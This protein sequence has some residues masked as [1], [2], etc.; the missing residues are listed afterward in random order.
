MGQNHSTKINA[1]FQALDV[2]G[3]GT[4]EKWELLRWL[5]FEPY[6]Q[7]SEESAWNSANKVML[8]MDKDG[9]T[10]ISKEEL[11]KYF[12]GWSI[13]EI[14]RATEVLL[15]RQNEEMEERE[16]DEL[17]RLA[18]LTISPSSNKKE[19]LIKLYRHFD[20]AMSGNV[21][22][23][24]LRKWYKEEP[25]FQ[26]DE[27]KDKGAQ[28]KAELDKLG[29]E[30]GYT[31]TEFTQLFE[32]WSDGEIRA[33]AKRLLSNPRRV[34][35]YRKVKVGSKLDRAE[36]KVKIKGQGG[37][38]EEIVRVVLPEAGGGFLT[39][40][41]MATTTAKT[42]K[43]LVSAKIENRRVRKGDVEAY[44]KSFNEDRF[45]ISLFPKDTEQASNLQNTDLVLQ[46]LDAS[47]M[48]RPY[49]IYLVA[50]D[51]LAEKYIMGIGRTRLDRWVTKP[52]EDI[53]SVYKLGRSLGTPGQFGYALLATHKQSGD[54]RAVKVITKTNFAR[55][56]ERKFHFQQ[57]RKEIEVMQ[58]LHHP[59]IVKMHE[60]FESP[61]D[62]FIVME[63]CLGGELFD[64]IRAKGTYTEQDASK[65]LRQMFEAVAYMHGKNIA[66]C[67]LKPDNFLFVTT[68]EDSK[69][70]VI[71]FGM[72]K[73]AT[74]RKYFQTLCGTSYYIA[75]EVIKGKYSVQCDIWSLGVVMFIMLYGYPPFYGN[76]QKLGSNTNAYIFS[77][78]KKGFQPELKKG[79][80]PFFNADVPVSESARNLI[81]KLLVMDP[82]ARL[83]AIEALQHPWLTGQTAS[84]VPM[85]KDFF[86]NLNQF[87]GSC[88]F[89]QEVL[90]LM[91]NVLHDDEIH[92][93]RE[94]FEQLDKDYEAFEQLDKDGDGEITVQEMTKALDTLSTKIHLRTK[95][96]M[97]RMAKDGKGQ[98]LSKP[99]PQLDAKQIFDT[100]DINKDGSLSYQELLMT[101][102]NKKILAN[103]ERMWQAFCKIDVNGN[104]VV[105]RTD[106]ERVLG[107]DGELVDSILKKID[108]DGDGLIDYEEFLEYWGVTQE[109]SHMRAASG[110]SMVP[111]GAE[112]LFR[113]DS[114][115]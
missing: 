104:G 112:R 31:Y 43:E 71:D 57:I 30:G 9:D 87:D 40:R 56:E 90:G 17:K 67:D 48:K 49:E 81:A 106:L 75:P 59:N 18:S 51:E 83:T 99:L 96:E 44:I 41:C 77:L 63:L 27:V 62:L 21:P 110:F 22:I 101:A 5:Q 16:V 38:R 64:R 52:T 93:L 89:K 58:A 45:A 19:A 95:S 46:E 84:T 39:V 7:S 69:V 82:A 37:G 47:G 97:D 14:A 88:R 72:S 74:R 102:V 100:V 79:F 4:I 109:E 65:V 61:T 42:L 94:A 68:A 86:Q 70:K 115:Q 23:S 6:F 73:F 36:A 33:I 111:G 50:M 85:I 76:P 60:T 92:Q 107:Q 91:V 11:A 114:E 3:N 78:I 32:Q 54:D 28:L 24:E 25:D 113:S 15:Q 12:K 8:E 53:R 13:E 108:K 98:G 105:S 2:D 1:I 29:P 80:G 66:H 55:T 10:H 103:E 35:D 20:T 26:S 34:T